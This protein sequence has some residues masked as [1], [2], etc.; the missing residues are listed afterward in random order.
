MMDARRPTTNGAIIEGNTTM[1]RSGTSGSCVWIVSGFDIGFTL[2]HQNNGPFPTE[3]RGSREEV[4][5]H[6]VTSSLL[7]RTSYLLL[8]SLTGLTVKGNGLAAILDD[9]SRDDALTDRI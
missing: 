9:L 7:P 8:P 4:R 1:S 2:P 6:L 5:G 3:G